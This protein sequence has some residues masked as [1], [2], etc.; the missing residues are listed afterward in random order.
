MLPSRELYEIRHRNNSRLSEPTTD[1]TIRDFSRV[2]HLEEAMM[3][4][5]RNLVDAAPLFCSSCSED[6]RCSTC[7]IRLARQFLYGH[8]EGCPRKVAAESSERSLPVM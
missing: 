8:E 7:A 1:P 6:M 5:I 3:Q 4:I 2:M